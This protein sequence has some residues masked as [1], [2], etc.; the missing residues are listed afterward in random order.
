M[1]SIVTSSFEPML[2]EALER[3]PVG[4]LGSV[5]PRHLEI[6]YDINDDFLAEVRARFPGYEA[7]VSRLS[8][9]DEHGER[10]VRMA[11]LAVLTSHSVN[12]V[13]ALHSE[14]MQQSI[15]ADFARLWPQRF[16]HQTNGI[17]PRRWLAQA[18]PARF[19]VIDGTRDAQA[20][21]ADV[22]R[23]ALARLPR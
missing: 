4:L 19:V 20:V 15:F 2:P 3:W 8:L 13:S 12:G 21:A 11:Y 18:N 5:L 7:L 14:L 10:R 17:T 16:N 1:G 22:L 6:I 23:A 9:I